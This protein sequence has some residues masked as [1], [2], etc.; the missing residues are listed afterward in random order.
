MI[1]AYTGDGKG[2]TTAAAGLLIRA[3]G[4]GKKVML[5]AFDKGNKT[6]KHNEVIVFE[7]L[8]IP[9]CITGLERML[10]NGGFRFNNS[11]EDKKEALRG[12][13]MAESAIKS[14]NFDLIVLD[15]ILTAVEYKLLDESCLCS[16]IKETPKSLELVLTGRTTNQHILQA[17]DLVTSMTKIKHYFDQG[18]DARPGIEY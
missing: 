1:Q 8:G 2:K 9:C 14:Q 6:Y 11:D 18:V 5:V 15:E 17:C 4:A 10:P 3:Y 7:K 16:L 13:R 12:F